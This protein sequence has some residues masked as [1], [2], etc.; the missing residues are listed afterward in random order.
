MFNSFFKSKRN[1]RNRYLGP[2]ATHLVLATLLLLMGVFSFGDAGFITTVHAQ[3]S[4]PTVN[5][6]SSSEYGACY[7]KRSS[8]AAYVYYQQTTRNNC[9]WQAYYNSTYN[10]RYGKWSTGNYGYT[11]YFRVNAS[12]QV[13]RWSG[14]TWIYWYNLF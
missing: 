2:K 14:S 11:T 13:S 9:V 7:T 6:Q 4:S 8:N 10:W 3:S 5:T 12:G 1:H